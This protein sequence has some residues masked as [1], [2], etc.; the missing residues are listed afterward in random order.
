MN[1]YELATMREKLSLNLPGMAARFGRSL[2]AGAGRGA[3]TGA[4]LGAVAGAAGEV[5]ADHEGMT[6]KEILGRGAARAVLGGAAGG[7]L[8]ATSGGAGRVVR[9]AKLLRPNEGTFSAVGKHVGGGFM[10]GAK[11]LGYTLTGKGDPHAMGVASSATAEK[12][13]NLLRLRAADELAANPARAKK[14]HSGLAADSRSERLRGAIGDHAIDTG[15][16]TLPGVVKGL[17]K[18][19]RATSR[20]LMTQMRAGGGSGMA[21]LG[22]G[23]PL[24]AGAGDIAMSGDESAQGGLSKTQKAVRAVGTA[25]ATA[26]TA[27]MPLLGGAAVGMGLDGLIHRATGGSRRPL[28]QAPSNP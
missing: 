16:S 6:A 8:G 1:S 14:I 24:A 12:K 7:M 10:R 23:L 25:G 26:L 15:T 11:R 17:A 20:A 2:T 3:A 5:A 18:D 28:P 13:I 9:D 22:V 19:P 21:M 4:G 27:G